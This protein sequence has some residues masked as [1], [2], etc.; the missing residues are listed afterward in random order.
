LIG[1]TTRFWVLQ[2]RFEVD[3]KCW[4]L[5]APV[6]P[7]LIRGRTD[8]LG[9]GL[10]SKPAF[11]ASCG[12]ESMPICVQRQ[13][14]GVGLAVE[15]NSEVHLKAATRIPRTTQSV[16][17]SSPFYHQCRF[18]SGALRAR[19]RFSNVAYTSDLKIIRG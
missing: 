12:A 6:G 18:P 3:L 14:L 19:S 16:D 13:D 5:A 11:Y 1:K 15:E 10:D 4:T 7:A 9:I 2:D 8:I 17:G